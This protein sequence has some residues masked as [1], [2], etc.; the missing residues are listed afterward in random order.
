[1][2]LAS[3]LSGAQT[4]PE[5]ESGVKP[6]SS[7]AGQVSGTLKMGSSETIKQLVDLWAADFQKHHVKA[8]VEN[9]AIHYVEAARAAKINVLPIPE[10]A[11]LVVVSHPISEDDLKLVAKNRGAEP[12][13]SPGPSMPSCWSSI[14]VTRCPG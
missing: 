11:D 14:T 9:E 10:G 12:F 1:M 7:Q 4:T 8:K 6:Y 5:V 2:C 3:G 13:A